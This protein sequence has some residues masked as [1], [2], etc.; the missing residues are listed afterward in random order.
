MKKT[1][2]IVLALAGFVVQ[3]GAADGGGFA[4][5]RKQQQARLLA[6]ID[7]TLATQ[8]ENAISDNFAAVRKADVQLQTGVGGRKGNIG[9]NLIGAFADA[10]DYAFGWQLR[11]FGGQDIDGGANAGVFYRRTNGEMLFGANAFADYENHKY[12]E[13]ARYSVGG[14]LSHSV[15]SLAANYY[16]PLTDNRKVNATLAAFSREGYDAQLR[17]AAPRFRQLKAAVDYYRFDG[18]GNTKAEDGFRYGVQ[19]H[20]TPALRLNLFYDDGGEKFGGDIAY[21]WTIGERQKRESDAAFAPD[22][23]AAVSRE[24]SQ[25]IATVATT[26]DNVRSVITTMR[27]TTRI[28]TAAVTT[29]TGMETM[30]AVTTR[31]TTEIMAAMTTTTTMTMH[32]ITPSR[33][34]SVELTVM[35]AVG[36]IAT[37]FGR[38]RVLVTLPSAPIIRPLVMTITTNRMTVFPDARVIVAEGAFAPFFPVGGGATFPL[39]SPP[40]RAYIATIVQG[41]EE[42][43]GEPTTTTLT[44]GTTTMTAAAVSTTMTMTM[45]AVSTT[46][47]MTMLAVSTTMRITTFSTMFITLTANA[48]MGDSRFRGNDGLLDSRFRPKGGSY[49]MAA[50]ERRGNDKQPSFPRKRADIFALTHPPRPFS[51]PRIPRHSRESGNL[52]LS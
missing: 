1:V 12:G 29:R 47:T 9:L 32:T 14:E 35:I 41:S 13:F 36:V 6:A 45:A 8:A 50:L 4:D 5:F 42:R 11:A 37:T 40:A 48:A 18:D 44:T 25:R 26:P 7:S 10:D 15:F 51:P 43:I 3:N 30:A 46:T 23:F 24:Y 31:T 20:P 19:W 27:T 34:A 52:L 22:M 2:L 39:P 38:S 49:E 28:T 21:A 16:V 33:V 17:I